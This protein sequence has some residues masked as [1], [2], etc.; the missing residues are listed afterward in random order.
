[1]VI[2]HAG[3]FILMNVDINNVFCSHSL[4]QMISAFLFPTKALTRKVLSL[5]LEKDNNYK[6]GHDQIFQY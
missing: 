5:N 4:H 1:M 2:I 3:L 6:S